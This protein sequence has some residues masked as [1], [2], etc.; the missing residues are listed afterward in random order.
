MNISEEELRAM[1]REAIA[2]TSPSSP[3]TMKAVEMRPSTGGIHPSHSRLALA[4]GGDAEGRCLIEPAVACTHCGY[5]QSMG[6]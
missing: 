4:V 2:R 5:C 1:V 6:H 3:K